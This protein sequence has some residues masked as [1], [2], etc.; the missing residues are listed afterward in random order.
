M[1]V[2]E[3]RP[4]DEHRLNCVGWAGNPAFEPQLFAELHQVT[5]GNPRKINQIFNRLLLL[6]AIEQITSI[7]CHMLH[8]VF[9]ELVQ[10]G[11]LPPPQDAP[12]QAPDIQIEPDVRPQAELQAEPDAQ[13]ELDVQPEPVADA[14]ESDTA[15]SFVIAQP[16]SV[17]DILVQHEAEIAWLQEMVRELVEAV[18]SE[19]QGGDDATGNA[20]GDE[21]AELKDRIAALETRFVQQES[22][23]RNVL[24]MLIQWIEKSGGGR[25]A[26]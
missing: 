6:G 18:G 13:A 1:E 21:V 10:E 15:G 16:S 9:A 23:L 5:G 24:A 25:E 19:D 22:V 2:D 17:D 20:A 26:A 12:S 11:A 7:D 14:A 8:Q 3:V 4:Y